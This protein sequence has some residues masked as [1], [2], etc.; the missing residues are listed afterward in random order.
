MLYTGVCNEPGDCQTSER[1]PV[2]W[3]PAATSV[4][5][6]DAERVFEPEPHGTLVFLFNFILV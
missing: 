6:S 2:L 1:A 5:L 4:W 3:E